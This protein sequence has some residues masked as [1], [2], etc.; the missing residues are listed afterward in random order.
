V[1]LGKKNIETKSH[2]ALNE[3]DYGIYTGK[4]KW[5]VKELVGEEKFQNLR[6][7][8]DVAIPKEKRLKMSTRASSPI[9]R[10]RS[11][12]TSSTA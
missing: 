1:A 2:K 3:R 8:W 4:N 9:S 5:E 12:R 11:C 6:R 7:G 10:K